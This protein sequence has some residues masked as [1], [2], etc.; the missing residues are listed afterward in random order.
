MGCRKTAP[1]RIQRRDC[2]GH[3]TDIADAEDQDPLDPTLVRGQWR[4]PKSTRRRASTARAIARSSADTAKSFARSATLFVGISGC[5][6]QFANGPSG[7]R[8]HRA[9]FRFAYRGSPRRNSELGHRQKEDQCEGDIL[10]QA[11][12]ILRHL[13]LDC[14]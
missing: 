1:D 7:L 5:I 9:H 3:V 6:V 14:K 11:A 4:K 2:R 8:T 12:D 13:R 10:H